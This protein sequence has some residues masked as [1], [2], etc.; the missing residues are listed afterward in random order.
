VDA[1]SAAAQHG[2]QLHQPDGGT[3][4][5]LLHGT[6]LMEGNKTRLAASI[7]NRQTAGGERR[8]TN[9]GPGRRS[10]ARLP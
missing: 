5:V 6:P 2:R 10:P 3:A 7:G 1:R 9:K 8:G 4:A